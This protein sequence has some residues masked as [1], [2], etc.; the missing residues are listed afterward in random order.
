ML[1]EKIDL[2]YH[3]HVAKLRKKIW[4]TKFKIEENEEKLSAM[5]VVAQSL[6]DRSWGISYKS[7]LQPLL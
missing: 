1:Q 5:N 3:R 2:Q 7:M 6:V 4:Q